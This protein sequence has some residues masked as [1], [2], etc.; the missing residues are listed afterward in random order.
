MNPLRELFNDKA[1]MAK[2]YRADMEFKDFV[3]AHNARGE[4]LANIAFGKSNAYA[5]NPK[6]SRAEVRARRGNKGK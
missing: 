3:K 4:M 5:G 6:P 1:F 2:Y